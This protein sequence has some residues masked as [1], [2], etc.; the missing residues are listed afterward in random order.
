MFETKMQW[1]ILGPKKNDGDSLCHDITRN[2]VMY[3]VP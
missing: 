3:K 2:F 1:K